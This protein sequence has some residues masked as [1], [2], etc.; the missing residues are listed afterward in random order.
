MICSCFPFRHI[1]RI[2]LGEG[3]GGRQYG[4]RVRGRKA[5]FRHAC[6]SVLHRRERRGMALHPVQQGLHGLAV[7]QRHS[8]PEAERQ[9]GG[10][11]KALPYVLAKREHGVFR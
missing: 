3:N 2:G 4:D 9:N 10:H 11:D 8:H 5:L 7:C 1:H 6:G